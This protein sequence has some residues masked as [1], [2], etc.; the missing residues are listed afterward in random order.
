MK[1]ALI[2]LCLLLVP[3][4][5]QAA[6][7]T[8]GN[9]FYATFMSGVSQ[10]TVTGIMAFSCNDFSQG[11]ISI[12]YETGDIGTGV[13]SSTLPIAIS[14][15][16]DF[17]D[18]NSKYYFFAFKGVSLGKLVFGMGSITDTASG[19]TMLGSFIGWF[20]GSLE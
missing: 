18:S 12:E 8:C 6:D 10:D 3:V 14:G 5:S 19:D 17:Y 2:V 20:A 1:K 9:Y 11:V 15:T 7:M 16:F 4:S 13:Y